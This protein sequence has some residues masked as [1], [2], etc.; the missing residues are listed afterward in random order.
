MIL[1]AC[2]LYFQT[3]FTENNCEH[4]IV[5][6]KDIKIGEVIAILDYMYKGEVNVVLEELPGMI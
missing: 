2:S 4:P 1:S 5:F 6:L 3:L